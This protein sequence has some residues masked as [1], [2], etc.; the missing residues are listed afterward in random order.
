MTAPAQ[1][2]KARLRLQRAQA[3]T[4]TFIAKH[5]DSPVSPA[6]TTKYGRL[7]AAEMKALIHLSDLEIGPS[8]ARPRKPK[9]SESPAE[10][11]RRI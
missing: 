9:K 7:L 10:T 6:D 11:Y 1:I 3:A 2:T 4:S 5:K 8:K